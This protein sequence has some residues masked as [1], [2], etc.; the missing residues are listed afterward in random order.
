M[1]LTFKYRIK[2]ATAS[3]R[4][5]RYAWASNQVWNYCCQIQKEAQSRRKA[6]CK[7]RWPSA[8][9]L[10]KLC[11]GSAAELGIHSD[12]VQTV[13]RQFVAS[14]DAK[15]RCP[16]FRAS[17]GPKKVLGWVPF[18][19]RAIRI[20]DDCI[21][22]LK[23]R[24]RFWKSRDI[25]GEIKAG[26]F[27]QDAQGKWYVAFQCEVIDTLPIGNGEIG[28]DLGLKTLATLS[29]GTKIPAVKHYRRYAAKLAVAQRAG[30]K[31][32]VKAIHAKI[33]NSRRHHL[34]EQTTIIAR[35]NQLIVVGNVNA[36]KLAKTRMAKSV[37]D[38]GWSM[39]RSQL[40]YKAR[41]HNAV[42]IEADERW[43]S[44]T[45]S[46]CGCIPDSSPKGMGALGMRH[47]TCSEC[48]VSHD[49]DINSA[50][51]ILRVGLER[52]PLAGEIPVL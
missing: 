38:A 33:A 2:D 36:A 24:F 3:K 26:C 5:S 50:L 44:Q 29:D 23:R 7:V 43:T 40:V 10:I 12:T 51:N 28:I 35:Q 48:G 30:N 11:T 1:L 47:W 39:F 16:R 13:C 45:C 52:Q 25:G 4:L 49:R 19:D 27:V 31:R 37:L 9:D 21:V 8:F 42:Y 17:S 46:C 15:R 20:N 32:R 41:R 18:I 22:Y 6:G 34:H 14:R